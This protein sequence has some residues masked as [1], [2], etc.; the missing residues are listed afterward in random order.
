M[1]LGRSGRAFREVEG[2]RYILFLSPLSTHA[3]GIAVGAGRQ[4]FTTCSRADSALNWLVIAALLAYRVLTPVFPEHRAAV[5]AYF[6]FLLTELVELAA[7]IVLNSF[8][9]ARNYGYE[10]RQL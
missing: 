5:L 4:M 6:D 10:F 8:N 9:T 3:N 2:V 1:K 7:S